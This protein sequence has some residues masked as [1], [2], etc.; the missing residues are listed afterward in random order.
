MKTRKFY[1]TAHDIIMADSV[2]LLLMYGLRALLLWGTFFI[3]MRA[4]NFEQYNKMNCP[5]RLP[6]QI[7]PSDLYQCSIYSRSKSRNICYFSYNMI[8]Y[9]YRIK[10]ETL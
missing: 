9:F 8:R 4:L 5:K 2:L 10:E 3:F 7:K 6:L 1:R